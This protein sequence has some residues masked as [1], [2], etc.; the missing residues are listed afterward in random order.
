MKKGH[1]KQR[2]FTYLS[3]EQRQALSLMNLVELNV[4]VDS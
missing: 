4:K 1:L 3:V 2:E